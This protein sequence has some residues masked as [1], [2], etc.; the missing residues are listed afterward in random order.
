MVALQPDPV[1]GSANLASS[2]VSKNTICAENGLNGTC[3]EAA[4]LGVLCATGPYIN[5]V[6]CGTRLGSARHAKR[7]HTTGTLILNL[8][9]SNLATPE[10]VT[11]GENDVVCTIT[12]SS[13]STIICQVHASDVW[14]EGAMSG[15]GNSGGQIIKMQDAGTGASSYHPSQSSPARISFALPEVNQA[16]GGRSTSGGSIITL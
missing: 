9:G 14:G 11:V 6:D 16:E 7:C 10:R 5:A 4:P 1:G 2:C 15:N 8:T 3:S 13:N 12:F